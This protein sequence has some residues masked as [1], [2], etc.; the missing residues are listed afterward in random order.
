[1]RGLAS[2]THTIEIGWS[3]G[4]LVLFDLVDYNGDE[5]AGIRVFNGGDG[6]QKS[7]Y[8]VD[9]AYPLWL[10]NVTAYKPH[11]V[12]ITSMCNDFG[13]GYTPNT[14]EQVKENLSSL[15]AKVRATGADPS[16]VICT[17]YERAGATD[18]IEPWANYVRVANEVAAAD[19]KVL[20][21]DMATRFGAGPFS[22]GNGQP[23]VDTDNTHPDGA[24]YQ[25]WADS[26][27]RFVSPA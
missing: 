18:A 11:L 6:G 1:M 3:S 2:G 8:W 7:S 15:I 27:S 14:S 21:F 19:A 10:G 13:G 16:F 24:G 20:T 25:L 22:G 4:G 12:V 9:D 26:L 23:L 17:E 5:S